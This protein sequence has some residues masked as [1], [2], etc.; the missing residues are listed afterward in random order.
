MSLLECD[1]PSVA[2]CGC[3]CLELAEQLRSC[4]NRLIVCT[5][6]EP[7]PGGR[8]YFTNVASVALGPR[9][10]KVASPSAVILSMVRAKSTGRLIA[11]QMPSAVS[12]T[13]RSV[14]AD[15]TIG[16]FGGAKLALPRRART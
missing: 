5:C 12:S 4:P 16:I 7:L 13:T 15:E 9:S 14:D 8:M 11:A 2:G 10:T 3:L 6:V 1:V